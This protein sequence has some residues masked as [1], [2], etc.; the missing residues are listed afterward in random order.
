MNRGQV[1]DMAGNAPSTPRKRDFARRR[2]MASLVMATLLLGACSN[3]ITGDSLKEKVQDAVG[4]ANAKPVK[5]TVQPDPNNPGGS[6]SLSGEVDEKIGVEFPLSTTVFSAYAFKNWTVSGSGTVLFTSTTSASTKV[7][8][9]AGPTSAAD[10]IVIQ[11]NYYNKPT[12]TVDPSKD[13]GVLINKKITLDFSQEMDPDTVIL[14]NVSVLEKSG[15]ATVFT[16][17]TSTY[18][19]KIVPLAGNV[20]YYLVYKS[21]QRLKQNYNYKVTLIPTSIKDKYQVPMERFDAQVF[22]TGTGIDEIAPAVN[23]VYVR[24]L[25]SDTSSTSSSMATGSNI[26]YLSVDAAD[27]IDGNVASIT[28]TEWIGGSQV[29]N[30]DEADAEHYD[31]GA[32]GGYKG[33]KI[34]YAEENIPYPIATAEGQGLRTIKIQATDGNGNITDIGAAGVATINYDTMPPA[35]VSGLSLT[36]LAGG[37]VR[38]D[39]SNP[40]DSDYYSA[41]LSWSWADSSHPGSTTVVSPT[42][43]Y[44]TPVLTDGSYTFSV[45]SVDTAGNESSTASGTKTTDSNPPATVTGL[46]ATPNSGGTVTLSWTNPGDPDY[47]QA[48]ISWTD[49]GTHTGSATAAYPLTTFTSGVLVDGSY[50]FS[51][52]T[53]DEIGNIQP[54]AVTKVAVADGTP[55]TVTITGPFTTS[56]GSTSL[57]ALKKGDT[58]YYKVV[59]GESS[60]ALTGV[61]VAAKISA[62]APTATV[63]TISASGSGLTWNIAVPIGAS[64]AEG[65]V[66][67][68]VAAGAVQDVAGNTSAQKDSASTFSVDNTAPTVAMTGPFPTSGGTTSLTA[69]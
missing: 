65:T 34:T 22:K 69:V 32:V 44:T 35:A 15:T 58:G 33:Y 28:V 51:V 57:T 54:T 47:A 48:N 18:F 10:P 45:R 26:A 2:S 62:I 68:R 16:D 39:W 38:L 20:G 21:G 49:G 17:V 3:L 7:T 37:K 30:Y 36:A 64:S 25:V 56:G 23:S 52:T 5:I 63:G 12:V 29:V 59:F 50:T 55:P 24:R 60:A 41:K 61:S 6:P 11:A 66:G 67:I 4:E 46:S 19:E 14:G 13:T 40:G 42:S 1:S 53:Q 31:D 8:V 9:K 27:N 43:T